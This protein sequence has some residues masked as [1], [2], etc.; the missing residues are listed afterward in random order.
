MNESRLIAISWKVG[1]QVNCNAV[2]WKKVDQVQYQSLR[3][4]LMY[5]AVCTRPDILHSV[6]KLAQ[7]NNDPDWGGDSIDRKS[8]TGYVF[9]L[10]GDVFLYELK[11]QSIALSSTKAEYIALTSAEKEAVFY[12]NFWGKWYSNLLRRSW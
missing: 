8:Y 12:N 7:W 11:K 2:P 4:W 9:I 3:G 6:C 5:L 10:S 1:Y